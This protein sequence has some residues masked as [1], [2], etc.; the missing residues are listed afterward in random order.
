MTPAEKL[1]EV[2]ENSERVKELNSELESILYGTDTGG[3]SF[4]DKFW[5]TY[6]NY[7]NRNYYYYAFTYGYWNDETFNPK[8]PIICSSSASANMML[9]GVTITDT[10][11]PIEIITAGNSTFKD[12]KTLKTIRKL[13]VYET[14]TFDNNIFYGCSSLENIIIEGVIGNDLRISYSPLN[15][16][17]IESV[18]NALS[19][20][21][22]GK[23]LTLKKA[24]VNNAFKVDVDDPTTYPEDSDWYKLR[25][26]KSNW[27]ISFA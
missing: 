22:T 17:S 14:T 12:C 24:A 19:P 2:Y 7:G 9:S 10:K 11:V 15:R 27:T 25:N 26:S 16:E 3:K 23:T 5:D 18:I 1:Q 13:I 21:A 8:Y 4:Y 20:T 6:Q